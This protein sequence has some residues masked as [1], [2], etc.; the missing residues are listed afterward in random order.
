MITK[1]ASNQLVLSDFFLPFEGKLN[2]DNRW[3]VLANYLPWEEMGKVYESKLSNDQGRVSISARCAIGALIIKHRLGFTDEETIAQIQENPYLQYFVGLSAFSDKKL[4]D[5]SLFVTIRKRLDVEDF[6]RLST[7]LQKSGEDLVIAEK[8]KNEENVSDKTEAEQGKDKAKGNTEK[9]KKVI[10]VDAS[11]A[12]QE[13]PYPT[14][15]SLLNVAR[16]Q[17]EKI[18]DFLWNLSD[19]KEGEKPRTYR[20]KAHRSFINAIR[21][22]QKS[23]EFWRKA[24]KEQLDFTRRNIKHINLLLDF[25]GEIPL[26]KRLLKTLWVITE[27]ERQ[28]RKMW[29]EK[30]NKCPHRI[31]NI[32][33]PHIRPIVRGKNGAKVEFGA[34]LSTSMEKGYVYL[35]K[36][37]W[38]NYNEG[39]YEVVECHLDKFSER[40]QGKLPDMFVGDKIYGNQ[41]AREKLKEKGVEFVGTPL[42]RKP[43]DKEKLEEREKNRKLHQQ[44]RS[45]MEGKFGETKR[46]GKLDKIKARRS[47]TSFSWIACILFV[48]NI[49][50]FQKEIFF[51]PIFGRLFQEF[52]TKMVQ[53]IFFQKKSVQITTS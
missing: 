9:E 38:D 11:A 39:F 35:D 4:F 53:N 49:K 20:D 41:K 15:L 16:L 7:Y 32:F 6:N 17:S 26:C 18:I 24:I 46:A 14:D 29:E 45:Q 10:T 33:Q 23:G 27:V 5:S 12:P 22:K 47:D 31:V 52:L 19:N 50:R 40:H 1:T 34:K 8:G 30:E 3:V 13:I 44:Q 25:F 28:Q 37:S 43:K 21:K 36:I 51:C 42:G 2:P 48:A